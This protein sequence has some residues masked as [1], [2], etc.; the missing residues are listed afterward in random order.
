MG[1]RVETAHARQPKD[2]GGGAGHADIKQRQAHTQFGCARRQTLPVEGLD[3]KELPE[4]PGNLNGNRDACWM[5]NGKIFPMAPYAIR[6]AI[7]N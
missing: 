7:W 4:K 3:A 2:E 5:Y 1:H 6:G